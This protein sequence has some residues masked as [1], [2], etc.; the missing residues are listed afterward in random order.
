MTNHRQLISY[1]A[2]AAPG[3]R[4]PATGDE[5]YLRPEIGFTP[6]WYREALGLDF[7]ERWHTDPGYR[8]ECQ[9]QMARELRRCFGDAPIGWLRDADQ[10]PDLLTGAFGACSVTAI[11][12]VPILYASDNWPVSAHRYLSAEDVMRLDPPDLDHNPFFDALMQQVE[13]IACEVG[14][15]HGYI[16]WQGTLNNA[17]RLRGEELFVDMIANPARASHL[18]ACVAATMTEAAQRLYARQRQSGVLVEHFTVSNCLVNMVSARQYRELLLPLDQR[19]AETFGLLGIHNCAWNADPYLESYVQV[20]HVGYI[21]MGLDSNLARARALFPHARRAL[22]YTPMDA[23]NN[24]SAALRRD[25]ERIAREYGPCDV[26]LADIEAGTSDAR[27]L[28]L[29]AL[30]DELSTN[31]PM[32]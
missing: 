31:P 26:V 9:R 14:P 12:G 16:N 15:V 28:E 8:W 21:D 24:S 17:Y 6:R 13:W 2:P 22:M 7:G 30:C 5:P 29:I 19:F 1:I 25:F 18:F 11:Y 20:P 4:R 27:V 3:T 32:P 10:S 23:A